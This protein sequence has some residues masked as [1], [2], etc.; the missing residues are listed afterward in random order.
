M[1]YTPEQVAAAHAFVAA[2]AHR[3]EL[4]VD[5]PAMTSLAWGAWND[6]YQAAYKAW[7]TADDA[8]WRLGLRDPAEARRIA[9]VH[10]A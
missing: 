2:D 1:T 6:R 9:T 5:E 8:C 7:Q 4:L 10:T 3:N